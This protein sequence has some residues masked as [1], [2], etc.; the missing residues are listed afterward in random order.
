MEILLFFTL[1][2]FNIHVCD[3]KEFSHTQLVFHGQ[4]LRNFHRSVKNFMDR[5]QKI[6]ENFHGRHFDFHGKK[7][8]AWVLG[9][10]E[11]WAPK[12]CIK[13]MGVCPTFFF[14]NAHLFLF[15]FMGILPTDRPSFFFMMPMFFIKF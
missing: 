5:Y 9:L 4:Y 1:T 6:S 13:K 8:A 12:K 10:P 7:S 3:I 15:Y 2:H 14:S 11:R